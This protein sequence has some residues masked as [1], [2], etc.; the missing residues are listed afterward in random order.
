[1]ATVDQSRISGEGLELLDCFVS[2]LDDMIYELAEEIAKKR[3]PSSSEVVQIEAEDVRNAAELVYGHLRSLVKT[4]KLPETIE[5]VIGSME[6]C[7]CGRGR[8]HADE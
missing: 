2:G 7:C 8:T 6:R 3:D 1:M 5:S 4:G